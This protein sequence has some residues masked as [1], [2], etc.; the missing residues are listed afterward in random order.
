[1]LN[2]AFMFK[3]DDKDKLQKFGVWLEKLIIENK[4]D[5]ESE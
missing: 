5:Y 1:M 3:V 4:F 2:G